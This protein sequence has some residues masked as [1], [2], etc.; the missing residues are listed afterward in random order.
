MKNFI[1]NFY[2]NTR[3]I[4]ILILAAIFGILFP[5]LIT[6][7]ILA[8]KN[9]QMRLNNLN[10]MG[11]NTATNLSIALRGHMWD[12][13]DDLAKELIQTVI[14][15]RDMKKIDVQDTTSN[16]TF[17]HVEKPSIEGENL[18]TFTKPITHQGK[19]IGKLTLVLS[20]YYVHEDIFRLKSQFF[21]IFAGQL[22]VSLILIFLMLYYKVLK[23][24][25]RLNHQAVHFSKEDFSRPFLWKRND[26][27]GIVGKNFENA[28]SELLKA[29]EFALH[30]KEQ[31]QKEVEE[32]TKELQELNENLKQRVDLELEKNKKQNILLQ[33]QTRLAALGE[34]MGNIAHQWRQPLSAHNQSK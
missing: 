9:E 13:R 20:D 18:L 16:K 23:P 29:Q 14:M 19:T 31:L 25:Q 3:L 34:M 12:L 7:Y 27:I 22:F 11:Q 5:A 8:N 6:G 32:K 10:F 4:Y 2:R 33:Q 15:H 28:R 17:V 30:Y 1:I 26:E 24:L 21:Y